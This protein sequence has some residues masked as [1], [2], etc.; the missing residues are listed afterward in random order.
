MEIIDTVHMGRVNWTN[1]DWSKKLSETLNK[2]FQT[3]PDTNI[4]VGWLAVDSSGFTHK[5]KY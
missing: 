4:S 5:I 3:V 1:H 2:G